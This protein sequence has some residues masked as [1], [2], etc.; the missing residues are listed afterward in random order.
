MIKR[1]DALIVRFTQFLVAHSKIGPDFASWEPY[2]AGLQNKAGIRRCRTV[3][4][5]A[6]PC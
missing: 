3:R 4:P 1:L 5:S 6:L 2:P